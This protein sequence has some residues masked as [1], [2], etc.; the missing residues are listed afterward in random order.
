MDKLKK[1]YDILEKYFN[2]QFH[3]ETTIVWRGGIPQYIRK[4]TENVTI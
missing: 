2:R 3:G 1:L 4:E